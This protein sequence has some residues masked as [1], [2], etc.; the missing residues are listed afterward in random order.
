MTIEQIIG[1]S[2]G[3]A[4]IV[5][6]LSVV[7]IGATVKISRS[8]GR[9]GEAIRNLANVVNELKEEVKKLSALQSEDRASIARL[10][11]KNG[12]RRR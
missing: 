12:S 7:M 4:A 8:D 6:P 5:V 1:F 2:I 11:G 10:Q 9:V 3:I